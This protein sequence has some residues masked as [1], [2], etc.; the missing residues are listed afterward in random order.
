MNSWVAGW[1]PIGQHFGILTRVHCYVGKWEKGRNRDLGVRG[2]Y[3]YMLVH[4][5]G[6]S[7]PELRFLSC[8]KDK[9]AYIL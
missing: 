9:K 2:T 4:T 1:D 7:R 8:R 6:F 5:Q 3:Y